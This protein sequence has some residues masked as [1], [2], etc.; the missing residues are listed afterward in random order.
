MVD[1]WRFMPLM[2]EVIAANADEAASAEGTHVA[3][4][5]HGL[6]DRCEAAIRETLRGGSGLADTSAGLS[7]EVD[8]VQRV[9]DHFDRAL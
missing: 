1:T 2:L 9:V 4:D 3:I 8:R 6:V 5:L 7:S